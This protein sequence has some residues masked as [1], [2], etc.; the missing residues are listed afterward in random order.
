MHICLM[1]LIEG[2]LN[3]THDFAFLRGLH[4]SHVFRVV[5]ADRPGMLQAGNGCDGS[6]LISF[7]ST[8]EWPTPVNAI[9]R[10]GTRS[11]FSK[12]PQHNIS[13]L[14]NHP[15]YAASANWPA[16]GVE[17]PLL[18]TIMVLFAFG[19]HCI[20]VAPVFPQSSELLLAVTA[21]V[22]GSA[23]RLGRMIVWDAESMRQS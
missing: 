17:W 13:Q 14:T 7:V 16:D 22:K 10:A 6:A 21:E 20:K 15:D 1:G 23:W 18:K 2:R 11:T 4:E 5:Q 3:L 8:S 19:R 9:F 12:N